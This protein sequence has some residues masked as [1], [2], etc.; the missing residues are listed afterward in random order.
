M[1]RGLEQPCSGLPSDR[2]SERKPRAI[3]RPLQ[4]LRTNNVLQVLS[5]PLLGAVHE[6]QVPRRVEA[7][8]AVKADSRWRGEEGDSTPV[9]RP[10]R[11]VGIS[12]ILAVAS[13][14]PEVQLIEPPALVAI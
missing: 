10:C 4:I 9:G 11:P 6:I 1:R 2:S 8:G 14:R 7:S 3:R 12:K 5:G 13:A